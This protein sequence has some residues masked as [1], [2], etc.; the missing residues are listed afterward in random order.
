MPAVDE[1]LAVEAA[2][3]PHAAPLNLLVGRRMS[4][5]FIILSHGRPVWTKTCC[6]DVF[7]NDRHERTAKTTL[8][9]FFAV[10]RTYLENADDVRKFACFDV[11]LRLKGVRCFG[12]CP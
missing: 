5:R 9:L 7:I 12:T 2:L 11:F 10:T 4:A 8:S 6:F 1:K 3:A